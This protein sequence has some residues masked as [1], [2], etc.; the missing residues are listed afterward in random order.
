VTAADF[1]RTRSLVSVQISSPASPSLGK[2]KTCVHHAPLCHAR[3]Q[4]S[5]RCRVDHRQAYHLH[6]T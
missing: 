2:L 6:R 1:R 4:T 5:H 3:T